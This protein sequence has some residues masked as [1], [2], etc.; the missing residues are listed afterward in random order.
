[1]ISYL[2]GIL[3][4]KKITTTGCQV[5]VEVNNIGYSI[6]IN[7][8][9]FTN[10]PNINSEI[11]IYTSLIHRE[12][13][14]IL[15][16]FLTSQE[17]ETFSILQTVSGVGMKAAL[18][19]LELPLS[20]IISAVISEDDKVICKIKGIGPKTAKRLILELKEKMITLKNELSIDVSENKDK[21]EDF[22]NISSAFEEAL[23][24]LTSLGYT[25]EEINLGLGSAK[26][27]ISDKND[28]QEIL[29]KA[30]AIISG[31]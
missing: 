2:R 12:D 25:K 20:E 3:I 9:T 11:C 14:M 6:V 18:A 17:R 16:G 28:T 22:C 7:K 21:A 4:T 5:I 31:N 19:I 8:K 24:V 15:C 23:A 30:L 13:A 27:C 29:Q 26:N 10:L 1:M